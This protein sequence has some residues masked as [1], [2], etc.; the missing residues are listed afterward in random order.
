MTTGGNEFSVPVKRHE[1]SLLYNSNSLLSSSIPGQSPS[2]SSSIGSGSEFRVSSPGGSYHF[3][4]TVSEI[5]EI[6]G[7]D[8][9]K[10][11][12]GEVY[13]VVSEDDL[14]RVGDPT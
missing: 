6:P 2:L 3:G 1:V 11:P 5:E 12:S 4:L 9:R 8:V 14:E 10:T 13:V 7:V